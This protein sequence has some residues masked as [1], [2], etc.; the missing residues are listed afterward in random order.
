MICRCAVATNRR[1]QHGS[2]RQEKATAGAVG[3][4]PQDV[5]G[6]SLGGVAEVGP[7]VAHHPSLQPAARAQRG[8]LVMP[9]GKSHKND[10][11]SKTDTQ[12]KE[13]VR[14]INAEVA[15]EAKRRVVQDRKAGKYDGNSGRR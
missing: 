7:L 10:D 8:V 3:E 13:T 12:T 2:V 1:G 9:W 6:E 4:V 14:R 5:A 11:V 15:A